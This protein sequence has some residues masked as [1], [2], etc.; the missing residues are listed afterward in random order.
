MTFKIDFAYIYI[1]YVCIYIKYHFARLTSAGEEVLLKKSL[2]E[3]VVVGI[4]CFLFYI[5][6]LRFSLAIGVG[7]Q[8]DLYFVLISLRR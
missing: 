7:G 5:V 8:D 4:V 6:F 2:I 3:T 1:E